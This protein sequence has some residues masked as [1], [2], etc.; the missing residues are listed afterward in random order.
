MVREVLFVKHSEPNNATIEVSV[1]AEDIVFS[2]QGD[3]E[4]SAILSLIR[5]PT[6]DWNAIKS[7]I[8]KQIQK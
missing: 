2:E 3:I 8:D 6:E 4:N 7:F 5:I 1:S